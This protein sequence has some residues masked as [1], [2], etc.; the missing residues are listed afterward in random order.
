MAKSYNQAYEIL[1][2]I[3]SNNYQWTTS[4]AQA[5]KKV[6]GIYEVNA[7]TSM[8]A[9]MS[10]IENMNKKLTMGGN[11]PMGQSMRLDFDRSKHFS[12]TTLT[13]YPTQGM[14]FC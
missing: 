5:G 13:K 2:T 6:A 4:R 11:Q 8:Q 10:S 1:E 14:K 3:A 7:A 12:N 9:Q